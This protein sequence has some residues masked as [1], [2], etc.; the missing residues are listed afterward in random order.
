MTS[1]PGGSITIHAH[2]AGDGSY[3]T[4]DSSNIAL[5]ISPESSTTTAQFLG[6][7]GSGFASTATSAYGD[8]ILLRA[9][10]VGASGQGIPTGTV[11]LMLDGALLG[12]Y[13][14]TAEGSVEVYTGTQ[15]SPGI[16]PV[17]GTHTL[18]ASFSGDGSFNASSSTTATLTVSR[19]VDHTAISGSSYSPPLNQTVFLTG[20]VVAQNIHMPIDPTG[21]IQFYDN[22]VA[23]GSPVTLVHSAPSTTSGGSQGSLPVAFSTTGKHVIT[24]TYAGDANFLP[25]TVGSTTLNP[26][27]PSGAATTVT[28]S[29]NASTPALGQ[30]VSFSVTVAHT[31]GSLTPTGTVTLTG[32]TS[33]FTGGSA[34]TKTLSFGRATV[35]Y[36]FITAGLT[37]LVIN[38][39]GDA[40]FAPSSGSVINLV[41][42]KGTPTSTLTPSSTVVL[43][44]TQVKLQT[45]LSA[46]TTSNGIP[47][48]T[49]TVQFYDSLNGGVA[50][51]LGLK[52]TLTVANGS[53]SYQTNSVVTKTT[54][55]AP[56]THSIYAVYAGDSNYN[57]VTT[58]TVSVTV[59]NP[60]FTVTA[61]SS[62]IT[63]LAGSSGTGTLQMNPI[64]GFSSA[65]ALTCDP[66]YVPA[67]MTCSVSPST[68]NGGSGSAVVTLTT[69]TPG[70]MARL[71]Q[72]DLSNLSAPLSCMILGL[73]LGWMRRRKRLGM[74]AL[75]GLV[76]CILIT[77]AGCSGNGISSTTVS[78]SSN[79]LKV[80][81]G[82]TV[83]FSA[84]VTS[85]NNQPTGAVNFTSDGNTIGEPAA[86]VNGLA[87]LDVTSL[88]VGIHTIVATYAGSSS[89]SSSTSN[90][91]L[92]AITGD[93]AVHVIATS[94]SLSH[95]TNIPVHIQ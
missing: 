38:Y 61:P 10:V 52:E 79:A 6:N 84:T 57:S 50:T 47:Y 75:L 17:V 90:K 43:P 77:T 39:S 49:G 11:N 86:V 81:S 89:T 56:G 2:Y 9:N 42:L 87:K 41:V 16:F 27:S 7:Y 5:T 21:T 18:S 44:S 85:A 80:A 3:N 45:L 36:S 29:V 63:V 40:N 65:V 15:T 8:D 70:P 23:I 46:S 94:G 25:A 32:G 34:N 13:T 1:L 76:L 20:F 58:Q 26:T 28:T 48:P 67:G 31:A 69:S 95:T 55:L 91:Y 12:T 37:P 35:V 88:P 68:V 64:L 33:S 60:D 22:G 53:A 62:G 71:M 93:T 92:Q 83:S 73:S 59:S 72:M 54:T 19:A 82:G 51:M 14:V 66:A 4:S 74:N 24:A 78:L 30:A